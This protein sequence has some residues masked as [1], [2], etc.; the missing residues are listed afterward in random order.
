[1]TSSEIN[2]YDRGFQA[3]METSSQIE[4][5]VGAGDT[6]DAVEALTAENE[7]LREQVRQLQAGFRPRRESRVYWLVVGAGILAFVAWF[8]A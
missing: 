7:S 2:A 6:K 3:A 4:F 1:M 8:L 5:L